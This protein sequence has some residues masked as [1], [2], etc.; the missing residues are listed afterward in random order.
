MRFVLYV[1]PSLDQMWVGPWSR[2]IWEVTR[3]GG[4]EAESHYLTERQVCPL[5]L[6]SAVSGVSGPRLPQ[7][8]A[9]AEVG[10]QRRSSPRNG[11]QRW[12]GP[13]MVLLEV[14]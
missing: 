3:G 1:A 13:L 11:G 12:L 8:Q 9:E 10:R 7:G 14:D 2:A 4:L 6:S 5:A